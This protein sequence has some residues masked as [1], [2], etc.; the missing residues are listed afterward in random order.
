MKIKDGRV[1]EISGFLG[2]V[3]ATIGNPSTAYYGAVVVLRDS[4]IT[5]IYGITVEH[6]FH[7]ATIKEEIS[8]KGERVVMVQRVRPIG[9]F[10]K[11]YIFG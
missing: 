8:R 5:M 2:D 7:W 10:G 3:V 1:I 11:P 6:G 4:D 9:M